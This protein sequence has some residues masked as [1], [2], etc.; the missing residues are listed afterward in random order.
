[1]SPTVPTILSAV[2][3]AVR[4]AMNAG[5]PANVLT[6][7]TKRRFWRDAQKFKTLFIRQ[8]PDLLPGRVNGW[9]IYR[10]G[11]RAEEAEE[12]WRF[13]SIHKVVLE[14]YMG[15]ADGDGS[16]D[17]AAFDAQ[18]EAIRDGLRL[19]TSVFGNTERTLPDVQGEE[20]STPVTIGDMTCW[21]ARL[22]LEAEATEIKSL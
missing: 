7:H 1:M 9:I 13:Y 8:S 20:I 2:S 6:V 18:I 3:L 5:T 17:Q 22:T 15:V 21:Y 16:G 11:V 4:T 19:N 14:G 12:R 10:D